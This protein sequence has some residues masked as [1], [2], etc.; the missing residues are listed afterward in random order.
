M[1]TGLLDAPV[2]PDTGGV[3]HR[4]RPTAFKGGRAVAVAALDGGSPMA[5]QT[6]DGPEGLKRVHG[7]FRRS[8]S[9]AG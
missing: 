2:T 1:R 8:A 6:G 9:V 7:Y 5:P 4:T 3:A